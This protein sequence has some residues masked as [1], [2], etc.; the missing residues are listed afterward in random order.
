M[1]ELQEM[2]RCAINLY[3]NFKLAKFECKQTAT[4]IVLSCVIC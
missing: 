2:K 1:N 3:A 4:N